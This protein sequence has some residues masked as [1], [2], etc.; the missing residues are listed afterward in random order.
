VGSLPVV[1]CLIG[2]PGPWP[3]SR[4][5]LAI[6][7]PQH[8]DEHRPKRPILLAVDQQLDTTRPV[9]RAARALGAAPVSE[10]CHGTDRSIDRW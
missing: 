5:V 10:T 6:A 7:L 2:D 4:Q 8:P 9:R 1:A 3:P